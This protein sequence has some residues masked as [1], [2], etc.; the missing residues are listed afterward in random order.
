MLQVCIFVPFLHSETPKPQNVT[1]SYPLKEH[2]QVPHIHLFKEIMN[3]RQKICT[4]QTKR[5]EYVNNLQMDPHEPIMNEQR[6]QKKKRND[7][8][9]SPE[10]HNLYLSND[11]RTTS[12]KRGARNNSM[13]VGSG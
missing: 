12:K 8:L 2:N 3:L 13:Y 6:I 1:K 7:S 10:A 4:E 11:K 9:S 5:K